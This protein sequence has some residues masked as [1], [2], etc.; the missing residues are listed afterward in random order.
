MFY[1]AS[2]P[3]RPWPW[4]QTTAQIARKRL[5]TKF[6]HNWSPLTLHPCQSTH[7]LHLLMLH[8]L[9]ITFLDK[10]RT[11]K[12]DY[13]LHHQLLP[14]PHHLRHLQ[15]SQF[16][17]I[18][19]QPHR[20]SPPLCHRPQ[21][22]INL[23]PKLQIPVLHPPS[24]YHGLQPSSR[25]PTFSIHQHL[26]H[27]QI[28]TLLSM[29]LRLLHDPI[30]LVH[31]NPLHPRPLAR[32]TQP[33]KQP[34]K[35]D[36]TAQ[37][38]S[39][40]V[41]TH[42][43]IHLWPLPFRIRIQYQ[44]LLL[45]PIRPNSQSLPILL[46]N[47]KIHFDS[48]K[49]NKLNNNSSCTAP[50]QLSTNVDSKI[51]YWLHLI[52]PHQLRHLHHIPHR[53]QPIHHRRLHQQLPAPLTPTYLRQPLLG[54][55]FLALPNP[56]LLLQGETLVHAG[57]PHQDPVDDITHPT[58][59][60]LS[61]ID[62][63]VLLS[64]AIVPQLPIPNTGELHLHNVADHLH[65][66]ALHHDIDDLPAIALLPIPYIGHEMLHTDPG[67]L[68][69]TL[70]QPTSCSHLP[71]THPILLE[72]MIQ[73]TMTLGETGTMPAIHHDPHD[74]LDL[75]LHGIIH[76]KCLLQKLHQAPRH[77][78]YLRGTARTRRW[79]THP[80]HWWT[81]NRATSNS[82]RC[83]RLRQIQPASN[84]SLSSTHPMLFPFA[85]RLLVKKKKNSIASW[86]RCF[87]DWLNPTPLRM[88]NKF[89]SVQM[90]ERLKTLLAL[91]AKPIV[92]TLPTHKKPKDSTSS[93]RTCWPS[94]FPRASQ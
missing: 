8:L 81:S 36:R 75:H 76:V 44:I 70:A 50:S 83:R 74:P 9:L 55:Q 48:F 84:V 91:L 16:P 65:D 57:R 1:R 69:A 58:K 86:T 82:R 30:A 32:V 89:G 10:L 17:D 94:Q 26:H 31:Q 92:L 52:L 18:H 59:V 80:C 40:A 11:F 67:H 6:I 24:I 90:K 33:W 20:W 85:M 54:H 63:H 53:L 51:N 41:H 49:L 78:E 45:H 64:F 73:M 22:H 14:R 71:T 62:V 4:I 3:L 25:P 5:N 46:N 79:T 56:H 87:D 28:D 66:I 34:P 2:H 60:Q 21:N 37:Q 43:P 38:T 42:R 13:H 93:T 72:L 47:F 88:G 61:A 19:H 23:V 12:R 15:R 29:F 35:S 77:R 39:P 27:H 68:L 7:R